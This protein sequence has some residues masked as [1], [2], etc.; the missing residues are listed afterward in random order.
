MCRNL[1]EVLQLALHVGVPQ[2]LVAFAA[3]PE[4]IAA[5]AELLGHFEGLLHLGGGIGER[6]GSSGSSRRRACSGGC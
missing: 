5:A 4:R 1:A 2:I 3:A 6:L